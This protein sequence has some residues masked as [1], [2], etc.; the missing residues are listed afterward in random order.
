[1]RERK[2]EKLHFQNF[3]IRLSIQSD[4]FAYNRP[5]FT[6]VKT[7][8]SNLEGEFT[9]KGEDCGGCLTGGQSN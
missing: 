4:I 3:T 7:Y 2:F 5:N 9:R 6:Y 8:F 1:M